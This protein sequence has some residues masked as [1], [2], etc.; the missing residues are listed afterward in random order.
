[1]DYILSTFLLLIN[2]YGLVRYRTQRSRDPVLLGVLHGLAILGHIVNIV[3]APVVLW[4]LWSTHGKSWRE[5]AVK[6]AAAAGV[7][8]GASYGLVIGVIQRPANAHDAWSWFLGSAGA[9]DNAQAFASGPSAAKLWTWLK[10]TRHI[11][12]SNR[13]EYANPPAW[14]FARYFL[15]G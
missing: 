6:Y 1:E 15:G 4:V 9:N 10:M 12:I 5:P 8:V 3:F 14:P 11:F 13:P 2:F 7:V